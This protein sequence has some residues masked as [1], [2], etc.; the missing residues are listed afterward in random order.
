MR[1]REKRPQIADTE[2]TTGENAATMKIF[3]DYETRSFCDLKASGGWKYSEHPTTDIICMAYAI[4]DGPVKHWLPGDSVP[5]EFLKADS[6]VARNVFFEYAITVNVAIPKYGFPER[7][8]DAS[9]Y[10][11]TA[12]L[13]RMHGLPASLEP[14]ADYLNKTFKKLPDGKR[15]IQ[16]YSLPVK[17]RK[18]GK[19]SF[20]PIPPDELKR[21]LDYNVLDVEADR[22]TYKTLSK[23]PNAEIERPVFLHDFNMNVRGVRIDTKALEKLLHV[24]ET[25]TERALAGPKS[26]TVEW[27]DKDGNKQ[28]AP[29]N[30]RSPQK[31]KIWLAA[32]GIEI[33]DCR[34]DTIEAAYDEAAARELED[35]KKVLAWRMFLAKAS[36]KKFRAA[37]DRVSPD[38]RLRYFLKYYGAHTGRFS[39][40]GFQIHNLPKA[41][42]KDGV[43]PVGEIARMIK[44]IT[45]DMPYM[46]IVDWSKRILPGLII[47]DAGN[48]FLSGDFS[49]VEARG[50]AWLAG[51]KK[52]L[53]EFERDDKIGDK[54]NDLYSRTARRIAGPEGKRQ[55]GKVSILAPIYGM[56]SAK[57]KTTAAKWGCEIS[58]AVA[59]KT[60]NYIRTSY[61]EIPAFWYGLE[62]A[63]RKTWITK[64]PH[65][66]GRIVFERGGNYIRVKLPSGRYLFYH[67][68]K[69][70]NGQI[71]YLNFG[72]KGARIKI[73]GGVLAEN[74]TQAT[75]RDIL[76]DRVIECGKTDIPVRL[77]VHDEIVGEIEKKKASRY[78]KVF[79]KILNT[80]PLWAEGFPLKTESEIAERYHK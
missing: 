59:E 73:W 57:M 28:K 3:F 40:E 29:L 15:L 2:N 33:D 75:C 65:T 50:I 45:P 36:V 74:I 31:L 34:V 70:E 77:H 58:D 48:V 69:I 11:C 43:D 53:A 44:E 80:A 21:W 49:A 52:M 68:V 63:F 46:Q 12:A 51:C 27:V 32:Q 39:G 1:G 19:L 38:G 37:F 78:Q 54:K 64:K 6:F 76:T 42:W 5:K 61:P 4:D 14:S 9:L 72:K 26:F 17:D 13:S 25:A 71:S 67:Q 47:P 55:F 18:T 7:M 60:I 8:K 30:V 79:D 20:R 66:V 56:G 41:K 23:L 62:D 10:E 16:L 35:V 24:V 22:E